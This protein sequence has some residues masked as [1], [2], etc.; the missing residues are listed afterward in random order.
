M[1]QRTKVLG[2]VGA[3]LAACIVLAAGALAQEVPACPPDVVFTWAH[4]GS[5]WDNSDHWTGGTSGEFPGSSLKNGDALIEN[6]ASG[7]PVWPQMSNSRCICNVTM[8]GAAQLDL[9]GKT[10]TAMVTGTFNSTSTST[11]VIF[12]NTAGTAAYLNMKGVVIQGGSNG[13]KLA[14]DSIAGQNIT[15]RTQTNPTCP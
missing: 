11:A 10:L 9:N 14:F 1:N 15:I 13:T 5:A 3:A 8:T 4:V 7:D 2:R 6:P 12:R